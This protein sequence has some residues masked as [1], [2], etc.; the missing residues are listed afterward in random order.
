MQQQSEGHEHVPAL[1]DAQTQDRRHL[2]IDPAGFSLEDAQHLIR[3]LQKDLQV[4]EQALHKHNSEL[5]LLNRVTRAF[6]STRELDQILI[7]V[8][9]EVRRL[10]E[11]DAGSIWLRDRKTGELVCEYAI[12]PYSQTVRG[13]RLAPGQGIAGAVA[14]SGE[15]V[16]V[17]DVFAD[18]RHFKGVDQRTGQTL[19]S[20]LCV[21]LKVKQD[22]IG[23]LQVLDTK[24][25]R[26]SDED[27]VLQELLATAAAIAIENARLN[28]KLWRAAE[29][30]SLLVNEIN[31]RGKNNLSVVAE[32]LSFTL[33]GRDQ[34]RSGKIL[35]TLLNRVN[36]LK[37][38]NTILAECE[39]TPFPLSELSSRIVH[40]SLEALEPEA[41]IFVAVPSSTIRLSPIYANTLALL[42]HEAV[43]NTVKHAMTGRKKGHISVHITRMDHTIHVEYRDDGPGF[44]DEILQS[45]PTHSGLRLLYRL[46]LEDLR[47]E[48]TL[49]NDN[50]AVVMMR[51]PF[52]SR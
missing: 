15:S 24:P 10:L 25:K 12:G 50:G 51:F 36:S 47:G 40:A 8:M 18:E 26:F 16:I 7:T 45:P 37:V 14:Q 3:E 46:L 42:M 13:W 31:Q 41:K 17:A 28:D 52:K 35:S 4:K 39:W 44:P 48:L 21:A 11:V 1:D 27:R 23:V 9:E 32:L 19:R 5:A 20:I 49:Y 43:T 38:V 29:T 34:Q 6:N 30:K 2:T 33:Q 22:S